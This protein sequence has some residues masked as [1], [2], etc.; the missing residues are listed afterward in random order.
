MI[1]PAP[2]GFTTMAAVA[3]VSAP[4]AANVQTTWLP[5]VQS[6]AGVVVTVTGVRP[7]GS[8]SV[9]VTGPSRATLLL[10]MTTV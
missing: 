3:L 6:A 1:T 8:V 2:A 9:N 10:V 7:P 5:S 4:S